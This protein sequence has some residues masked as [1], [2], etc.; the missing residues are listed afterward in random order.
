MLRR[1]L[2]EGNIYYLPKNS[3]ICPALVETEIS[4]KYSPKDRHYYEKHYKI[5]KGILDYIVH[6]K[7]SNIIFIKYQE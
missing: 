4:E 1:T 2:L 7:L 5:K 6:L 3:R